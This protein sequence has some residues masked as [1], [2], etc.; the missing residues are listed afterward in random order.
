MDPE[1]RGTGPGAPV[2]R[3]PRGHRLTGEGTSQSSRL[4]LGPPGFLLERGAK[5]WR[6]H[7]A[8]R[9]PHTLEPSPGF[10]L[11]WLLTCRRH[12][13]ANASVLRGQKF[14]GNRSWQPPHSKPS[15]PT[16]PPFQCTP[17][18]K[19]RCLGCSAG[20]DPLLL[21]PWAQT[22][23]SNWTRSDWLADTVEGAPRTAGAC[24][25]GHHH[26]RARCSAEQ[27]Q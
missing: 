4:A 10:S 8:T 21:P 7:T 17:I 2:R 19:P 12:R 26:H 1:A 5:P 20:R 16:V 22:A 15:Q 3:Q 11:P 24:C 23:R 9:K 18:G 6:M 14:T 25:A 13:E 27:R